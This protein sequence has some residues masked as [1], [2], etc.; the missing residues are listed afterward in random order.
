[1]AASRVFIDSRLNDKELLISHFAPGTEY[2]VLDANQDGI[3]QIVTALSGQ[4]GYDSIQI[5]SHG[6]TGSITIGSTV[7]NNSTLDFYASQLAFIGN[8]LTENGDLLLYGCNVGAGDQGRQFIETLSQ[9]TGADVA[10]SDDPTGGS[11]AGGDWTLEVQTGVVK[12]AATVDVLDYGYLL[13]NSI[14]TVSGPLATMVAEGAAS[15]SLNLLA[16]AHDADLTDTLR[17]GS[18][19]FTVNGVASALPAGITL[20][21]NTLTI[22]PG[23]TAYNALAQGE[24]KTIV[25][26]YRVLD[27]SVAEEISFAPK[28]DYATG[29]FP[30]SVTSA[31]V[32]GD[33]KSD[34][35]VANMSGLI[36]GTVSVLKNNGNGTFATRFNY[37][38]GAAP[39]SVASTD[40]N[41]DGKFDLIVANLNSDTLSV[42][43]N[44]GNGTFAYKVDYVTGSRPYSVTSADVNGD[45][46]SDLIVV[47]RS[48]HTV[49]VLKNNGNGYFATKADYTTGSYP[50]SVTSADV[51]GDGK[52]DLIIANA[53]SNTLSVLKNNG[54]GT[55]ATKVDYATG[56]APCSVMS[57]D[58]NGDGKSDLIVANAGSNTLSVLKNN[59]DG[60]F[61]TKVDYVTGSRPYSVT[62]ADVN[63]D[64]MSDLIV[65]N[66]DSNTLSVLKNNGDGTFATKVDYAT[67][68][69]PESV[70]SSDVNGD[71]KF[72]L[73]VANNNS[74]GTVSVL[75]N[76]STGF[77]AYPTTTQTITINGTNDAPVAVADISSTTKNSILTATAATG[78]L[79]NDTDP[80]TSDTHSVTAVNGST[81]N[82][83]KSVTGN[84]GGSFTINSDGSYSFDPGADF[85]SLFSGQSATTQVSYTNSDNHGGVS[86]S[87]LTVT[88]NGVGTDTIAPTLT[89]FSP[90]DAAT[91][92]AVYSRIELTFNEAI[93][94]GTGTIQ[95]H[96]GSVIGPVVESRLWI[97][98]N[99]L[100][101]IPLADFTTNTHY[102]VT[103]ADGSVKDLAGN[104]FAGTDSYDFTTMPLGM[105]KVMTDFG[106]WESVSSVFVQ[107]DGKVLV[108]GNSTIADVTSCGAL[109]RYN[110]NGSLD[111]TFSGD[112]KL[113]TAP[114]FGSYIGYGSSV[115][116]QA[117]GKILVAG[118][119]YLSGDNSDFALARYNTDGS[120][121]TGFGNGGKVT[122]D[123][124]NNSD[125]GNSVVVQTDGKI[126]V[127]GS[128]GNDFALTRYNSDGTLDITF[129]GDGKLTTDLGGS[130]DAQSFVVKGD[131]KIFVAGYTYNDNNYHEDL[132]FACY[133]SDGSLDKTFSDDGKL[134]VPFFDGSGSS[135]CSVLAQ[136]DGKILVAGYISNSNGDLDFALARYN[137]DGSL[138][139]TFSEDGKVTTDF[140]NWDNASSIV[141]QL[142]G[143]IVVAGTSGNDFALV[144]YNSDG[145]LDLSFSDDGKVTTDFGNQDYGYSVVVQTDGKIVVAGASG[146]NFALARYNSDGSL[147]ASFGN[148]PVTG[149][150]CVD[151]LYGGTGN[152][153][154]DGGA[155]NDF[156]Y[157]DTGNDSMYGGTGN[158]ELQGGDGDD[159][160]AGNG[161]N[162]TLDGGA[163][164]DTAVFSGNFE[165][166]TVNYDAATSMYTVVDKIADRDGTDVIIAVE[167][168]QFADGTKS[169]ADS[170]T[171]APTVISFTP[172]DA[173]TGVVVGSDIV[174][175]FSEAIQKGT[176]TIAIHSGSADGPVVESYDVATNSANLAVS[177]NTLTINPS[178]DL[179]GS[180]HYFVTFSDGSVEDL[181]GNHF[182]GTDTYDFTT[183]AISEPVVMDG[184]VTTDFG[185]NDFGF[186]MAMQSDGKIVVG[187]ISDGDFALARYTANGILDTTFSGD[188]K[189]TTDFV[190]NAFVYGV[191]VQPDGKILLAGD[192]N[193]HF[194]LARY[195]A[196]GSLDTSFSGDGK[197]TTSFDGSYSESAYGLK[198]QAD[199]KIL[200]AG[201]AYMDSN[202]DFALARYNTD[203]SL[204]TVFG[205]GGK[206]TTDIG[207][208]DEGSSV[209]V[210]S[211]G[212]I[213]LA[214]S[215]WSWEANAGEGDFALVRY[216]SNGLLDA[217]F[218]AGGKVITDFGGD[219]S[220]YGMA[221][222]SDGKILL[223]GRSNGD[224]A[225]ARYNTNGTLDTTF[226]GDGKVTTDFGG[227]DFGMGMTVQGDGKILVSGYA[228][229]NQDFLFDRQPD[230]SVLFFDGVSSDFALMRYNADGTLDTSFG[231]GGKLTTDFGG[232]DYGASVAV[233]A[234]GKIMV[235]GG[236][237]GDFA[238]A[239]Y[240]S[241]G[242][243]DTS[244]GTVS[245]TTPFHDFSGTV[246]FW[247]TGAPITGV[248]TTLTSVPATGTHPIEFRNIQVAADGTRTIEI[249]ETSARSDIDSLQLEIALPTG[250]TAQWQD[251]AGLPSGW[252]SLANTRITGQFIL[253][254]MGIT[255]LSAGPVKLGTLTFTAST[256]E[257]HF[258]LA[259]SKGQLGNDAISSF[260]ISSDSTITGLDGLYQYHDMAD[261]GYTLTS[262]KVSGIAESNAIMANDA[263][264]AL[265]I[266]VGMNPNTDGAAIS[267]YQYLA[268]DVNRDGQVKSADA[269]NILKMAVKL[270][271]APASEW[272][273]VPESVGSESMTR[274]S[275]IWPDNSTPVTL[276]HDL[277]LNLIGIVKGDVNGSWVA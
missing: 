204:D 155:G 165:E 196:D 180:T 27:I 6:A 144:R 262:A 89:S 11:S 131:G 78:I 229:A 150:E 13:A 231:I 243:L 2:Q 83:G 198:V 178:N 213:I 246:T 97:S 52:S 54:D 238:L 61:A 148:D 166:Y 214:G 164:N 250:S 86:S 147:D 153:W 244:F 135:R 108:V 91:G 56:S 74:S 132:A 48:V 186:G 129:D 81:G 94:L 183:E 139:T 208:D 115:L 124:G 258:D 72:D 149:T 62:S 7:L 119:I 257:Q 255:A 193:E 211:D 10:A 157:G 265:K 76:N 68:T 220:S 24:Q 71:G 75:I 239:R 167:N 21:G 102:F 8:A 171:D 145:T 241:D 189:V 158:D 194:A 221:I 152:D 32:N 126:V 34:L 51:S 117:D 133:N 18:V 175:D 254:G 29:N 130:D 210:Q 92:V 226:S 98:A 276:D 242:S 46:M 64:G 225:L 181:A 118:T 14:P 103:I 4:S 162:D 106:D 114:F 53:G 205:I 116:M 25:V 161:G 235:S 80:D 154:M 203:G 60:T 206:V 252:S 227:G 100:T 224:V 185:G 233:Q 182:T 188:G 271:T 40:V 249:W 15:V 41:S 190:G 17:V 199:G 259:L 267:P 209:A 22:D 247:K 177:G 143:K 137:S 66:V 105:G 65:A 59:G 19:S 217:S 232:T 28:V 168:F 50:D 35:I 104:S 125:S 266:A 261:G 160:L 73:I 39:I 128:S 264:A 84:H 70:T 146:A 49:S 230:G 236:S 245:D 138:D 31:D 173:A 112:G 33:G 195:N 9:L 140:G 179:A 5:I 45:G 201:A 253:G 90:L 248:M 172:A 38:T 142:D 187:G 192:D 30:S 120:L 212:K 109:A 95:L 273:F 110:V 240:N 223:M 263:L 136:A 141:I 69:T 107:G 26:T 275:V 43:K 237:N 176:G 20:N 12:Q 58:V 67:G 169:A 234:D 163:G 222:Q 77:S 174:L 134:T 1:M 44:T 218:G 269:L 202:S 268:A 79:V 111:T 57:A 122:T 93:Q 101:I 127:A 170:V 200:V 3:E 37:E 36:N 219:D 260:G 23:N 42:L 87:T 197:V 272:L 113:I 96:R 16:N 191:A 156:L 85:I 228:H 151:T 99:T 184:K 251:D 88:V 121:D 274:N 277:E 63:G 256:D 47:N 123:F 159:L 82:V 215:T 270:D 216:T 55:F 207:N